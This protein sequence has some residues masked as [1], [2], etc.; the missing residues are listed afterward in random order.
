MQ[1]FKIAL[2]TLVVGILAL[3]AAAAGVVYSGAYNVAAT[4]KHWPITYWVL[5]QA[6]HRSVER[7]SADIEAP[8]LGGEQQLLAGAANF[9]AMCAGCH[10]PPGARPSVAAQGMNPEPPGLAHA[11]AEMSASEIYWI[12]K[13]GIKA[14]GMPAWGSTHS[15]ADLW[16]MT[17][18]VKQWPEMSET[19]YEQMLASAET[20]GI[21]HHAGGGGHDGG[22]HSDGQGDDQGGGHHNGGGKGSDGNNA[23]HKSGGHGDGDQGGG[24]DDGGN[25][26][27]V[28]NNSDDKAG[29]HDDTDGRDS[30]ADSHNDDGHA[31]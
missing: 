31:H 30:A 18:F 10:A 1:V 17:A 26:S 6:V 29:G 14:S 12:L 11:G 19:D 13:H 23:D 24:H 5:N 4:D 20:S 8:E 25:K 21:G 16:A 15:D 27:S 28:G 2:T 22:G 7:Q 9:D 3:G